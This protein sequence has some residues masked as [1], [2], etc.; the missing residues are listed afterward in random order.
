METPLLQLYCSQAQHPD[1]SHFSFTFSLLSFIC[2]GEQAVFR[3]CAVPAAVGLRTDWMDPMA[4]VM[5]KQA[6][7]EWGHFAV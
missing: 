6:T 4:S 3:S 5:L 1:I 2:T 7:G